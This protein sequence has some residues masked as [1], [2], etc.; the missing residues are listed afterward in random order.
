MYPPALASFSNTQTPKISLDGVEMPLNEIV[1]LFL[2]N[3]QT[4][5]QVGDRDDAE[6]EGASSMQPSGQK[7]KE[8]IDQKLEKR[9]EMLGDEFGVLR[10]GIKH[11]LK[12]SNLE[13]ERNK[14]VL[15]RKELH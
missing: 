11:I 7:K 2:K 8:Y 6:N 3:L 9:V 4:I 1:S 15:R 10:D 12:I 5:C 14:Y 13:A